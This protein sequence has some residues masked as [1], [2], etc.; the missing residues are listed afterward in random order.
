MTTDTAASHSTVL[1]TD[2]RS[3]HALATVRDLA[4]AGRV[5]VVAG[6]EA[7]TRAYAAASRYVAAYE[8]L[9][10]LD[11]PAAPVRS[12]MEEIVARHRIVAVIT[13]SDRTIARLR[14]LDVCVPTV[15][16]MGPGL[17]AVIDK[18]ELAKVC[19]LADVAYPA[20]EPVGDAVE[21]A[22]DVVIKARASAVS[23]RAR[24]TS[25]TGAFVAHDGRQAEAAVIALRQSGL[26][27]IVQRRVERRYKVNVSIVRRRGHT[28]FRI[29]YR[30]LREFP[31]EGG[32]AAAVESLDAAGGVG[33]RAIAAAERVCDAAGY[34]GL[35]NVEFYGQSDGTLCLIEVNARAWGSIGFASQLGLE[36]AERA[37]RDAIGEPPEDPLPYPAGRRWHRPMLEL[38]WIASRSPERP[39]LRQMGHTLGLGDAWD[40]V[41]LRDPL[42]MAFALG[43]GAGRAVGAGLSLVRRRR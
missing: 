20:T 40:I 43:Q 24:V 30:V 14:H 35:A 4:R 27:P 36:P 21:I 8:R 10:S 39:P 23:D 6:D 34:D 38:R 41:S 28:R 16:E 19:Q 32:I 33:A 12:A 37:V 7:R 31:V 29:A 18:L 11:G 26:E 1:V 5:V 17:D 13:C 25:H 22:G 42:P 15:P 3:W 9:P 2:P